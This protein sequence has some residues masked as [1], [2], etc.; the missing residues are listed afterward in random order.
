MNAVEEKNMAELFQIESTVCH[1]PIAASYVEI[2]LG[3]KI[4][5]RHP[6]WVS[7][8][9]SQTSSV[10]Q[11]GESERLS[12]GKLHLLSFNQMTLF[13]FCKIRYA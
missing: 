1:Q 10:V 7:T 3:R 13:F 8:L 9:K 11:V 4:A 2:H 5:C 12:E 6:A